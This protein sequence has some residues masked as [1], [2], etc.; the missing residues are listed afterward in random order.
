M[1]ILRR[2]YDP[3]AIRTI[4]TDEELWERISEEDLSKDQ[5]DV[6]FD[7]PNYIWLGVYRDDLLIGIIFLQPENLTTLD[8]HL[9]LLKEYRVF[10]K[11]VG[12]AFLKYFLKLPERINKIVVKI[13][14][15]Y[16]EVVFFALSMG[17]KK[18]GLS[19]QSIKI[20]GQFIDRVLLGMTKEEAK[21]WVQQQHSQGQS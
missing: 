6:H 20:K 12:R 19:P 3:I 14:I 2:I 17:M 16:K 9:N 11:I 18:E 1:I 8:V 13:P 7:N 21:Q 4:L 15:I 5:F 10:R